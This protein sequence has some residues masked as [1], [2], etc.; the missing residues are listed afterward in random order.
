MR[1]KHICL[2]AEMDTYLY[3][4]FFNLYGDLIIESVAK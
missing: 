2:K 1:L 3:G 4:G